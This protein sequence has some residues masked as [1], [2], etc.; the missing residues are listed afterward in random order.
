MYK[1]TLAILLASATL[2]ACGSRPENPVDYV[3]YRDEP[4]VKQVENGMTMQKVIAIGGSPSSVIDLPHGGTCND[5]ILN[6]DGKQQPYYVRFDA[7][8]HVDAKGFKTCKQRQEDSDA[9]HGA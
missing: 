7:T 6:H 4:L 8:G 5:Y 1:Q 2:A 9:L 3:T